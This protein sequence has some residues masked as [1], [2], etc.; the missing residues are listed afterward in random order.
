LTNIIIRISDHELRNCS[1]SGYGAIHVACRY[2]N[3]FALTLILDKGI[4]ID[5]LDTNGNTPLHYASKYGNIDICKC[6]VERKC[7]PAKRNAQNATPYD[8]AENHVVRQFLLPIQL[9]SER[10]AQEAL[11]IDPMSQY[12]MPPMLG[13]EY[14]VYSV[15]VSQQIPTGAAPEYPVYSMSAAQPIP[16]PEYPVYS[17]GVAQPQSIPAPEY[18]V[19]SL[20]TT[21]AAPQSA[22]PS[23][24]PAPEYPVYSI[25]T[26]SAISNPPSATHPAKLNIPQ[27]VV[28]NPGNAISNSGNT[29]P[30]YTTITAALP[31]PN[32]APSLTGS[33]IG[34]TSTMVPSVPSIP[35]SSQFQQ[36]P[37]TYSGVQLPAHPDK[38]IPIT[39]VNIPQPQNSNFSNN[40]KRAIQPDGFH[41]SASDPVLQARYGHVKASINIAPPPTSFPASTGAPQYG[42]YNNGVN[43]T[44]PSN[45][46]SRYVAYD[47]HTNSAI[48]PPAHNVMQMPVYSQPQYQIPATSIPMQQQQFTNLPPYK[49]EEHVAP[50]PMNVQPIQ[51]RNI[52]VFNPTTDDVI[53]ASSSS[54]SVL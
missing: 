45:V 42:L 23:P 38:T 49:S 50:L 40:N 24:T 35:S 11:G 1:D 18:P 33:N 6:L 14:P 36:V 25:G 34:S 29:S 15:G 28:S 47:V 41:S 13:T 4:P 27:R 3:R 5:L 10:E 12:G 21:T 8:V 30:T 9:S 54:S 31:K 43:P 53:S 32:S 20:G 19:Y 46:F 2:N 48:P 37:P 39:P 52:A 51:N 22:A 44:A 7:S 16:T 26:Q 17:V